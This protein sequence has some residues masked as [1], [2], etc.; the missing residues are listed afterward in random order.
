MNRVE[1]ARQ[2]DEEAADWAVR[3]E[4]HESDPVFAAALEAWLAADPRRQGALLRAEAALSYLNRGRALGRVD[5]ETSRPHR[6]TRRGLIVGGGAL[7]AMAAGV[8]GLAFLLSQPESYH[9]A[10]GE[11]R[12]VPLA[13]GSLS[14]INTDTNIQV[15]MTSDLRRLIL[16]KGEA[17]F[18]VAKD[19][20]RPF[21]VE[22][23][24]VRDRK[25]VV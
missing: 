6:I 1:S 16:T 21:L 19:P 2:I 13:D 3:R 12:K 14:A 25:S 20:K 23:G 11:V 18:N 9:T 15:A 24:D 5:T 8:A 17:W 7:A 10:F 22:A 4:E